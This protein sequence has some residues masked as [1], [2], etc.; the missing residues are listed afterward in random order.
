MRATTVFLAI[1]G[2]ASKVWAAPMSTNETAS[3]ASVGK[4]WA[5]GSCGVHV[6]LVVSHAKKMYFTTVKIYD[7]AQIYIST[8]DWGVPTDDAPFQG[9]VD[10]LGY[11]LH[12]RVLAH[13]DHL[14][15]SHFTFSPPLSLMLDFL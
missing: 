8:A 4:R 3:V 7:G 10:G 11:P 14:V 12:V 6:R 1:I 13:K 15:S 2:L 9:A 5:K